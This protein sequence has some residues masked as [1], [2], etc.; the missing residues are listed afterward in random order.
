MHRERL[1]EEQKT[2]E[3]IKKM[4]DYLMNDQ[5]MTIQEKLNHNNK[6]NKKVKTSCGFRYGKLA[7]KQG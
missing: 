1:I 2:D 3:E 5:S 4:Q 6:K 7:T